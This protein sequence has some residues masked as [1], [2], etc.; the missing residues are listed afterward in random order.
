M[1]TVRLVAISF[2]TDNVVTVS[3][4]AIILVAI[5][6]VTDNVPVIVSLVTDKPVTNSSVADVYW[7]RH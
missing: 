4:V 1:V 7:H 3:F 2:V 5:S 6:L